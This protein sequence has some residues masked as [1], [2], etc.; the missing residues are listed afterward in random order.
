MIEMYVITTVTNVD[1]YSVDDS[2]D[3]KGIVIFG[4]S[5]A[6]DTFNS[7]MDGMETEPEICYDRITLYHAVID[8]RGIVVP[9][10][11]PIDDWMDDYYR[12]STLQEKRLWQLIYGRS[13]F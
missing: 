12:E 2:K 1:G 3:G 10:G 5:N 7:M 8:D 9:V 4:E 6:N 11:E 13:D